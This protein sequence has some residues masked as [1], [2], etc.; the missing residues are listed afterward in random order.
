VLCSITFQHG[1]A[2]IELGGVPIFGGAHE[3]ASSSFYY[4]DVVEEEIKIITRCVQA[5]IFIVFLCKTVYEAEIVDSF[6]NVHQFCVCSTAG[7]RQQRLQDDVENA[8]S[9]R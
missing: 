9:D 7:F 8:A 2:S 3:L 1:Q 4:Y 6:Y 5:S